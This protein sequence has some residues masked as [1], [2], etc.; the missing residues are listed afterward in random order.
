MNDIVTA[1]AAE[2]GRIDAVAGDGDHGVGM[3]RGLGAAYEVSIDHPGGPSTVLRDAAYAFGDKAGG[4]SGALWGAFLGGIARAL[5][6]DRE[7]TATEIATAICAGT[8]ALQALGKCELEDK[9][10][11]DAIKPFANDLAAR[12]A[13]GE[14]LAE[15]WAASA[16]LATEK[17][18]A[19]VDLMAKLGR[20]R[21]LGEKSLGTPDPGATSMAALLVAVSR[22]ITC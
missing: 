14:S 4:S 19:T 18:A 7:A 2:W 1:S 10:M 6:D 11:Y 16:N 12:V 17:A 13:A 8:E 22:V 5:P 3:A 9:T 20:A 21:P 15:A